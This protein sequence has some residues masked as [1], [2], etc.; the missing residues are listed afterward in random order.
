MKKKGHNIIA[1][2]SY[3][4]G[5]GKTWFAATLAHALSGLKQRVLFFDADLGLANIDSQLGLN[6]KDGLNSVINGHKSLN[7]IICPYEKA[8][9]DIIS[10]AEG[11]QG[12]SK[13]P[14]GRLQILGED[15]NLLSADYN[16]VIL[17][18]GGF[19]SK[20]Q[21]ILS[22]LAG[23]IILLCNSAPSSMVEA[24]AYIQNIHKLFPHVEISIVVNQA[25]SH[26]EGSRTFETLH[27]ACSKF[28]NFSP[29]ILGVVR[30]DTRVR[31]AIRSKMP[32]LS[33]YP[34]SEAAED[35]IKTAG[36]LI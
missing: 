25:H 12:F 27:S 20:T 31:D 4:R 19:S 8:R 22:G 33:R 32:L 10:D 7:Q 5:I 6:L 15:L 17:D 2:A 26:I 1:V 35:V 16:H 24:Y 9:L 21:H 11:T 34:S 18:I 23:R 30:Q 3:N 13:M 14:V 29:Q 36:K 28:L